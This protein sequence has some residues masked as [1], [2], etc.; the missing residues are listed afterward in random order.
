MKSILIFILFI[1][2]S[3]GCNQA[4]EISN[5]DR[6]LLIS[7]E[8]NVSGI[9]ELN[10]ELYENSQVKDSAFNSMISS[11]LYKLHQL[12][13]Y[14]VEASGGYQG[15]FP[16]RTE[17]VNNLS[18]ESSLILKQNPYGITVDYLN[19][20]PNY[21]KTKGLKVG[22]IAVNPKDDPFGK[23]S[24]DN[25]DWFDLAFPEKNVYHVLIV[26]ENLKSQILMLERRYLQSRLN[27]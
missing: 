19:Q 23:D 11:T 18:G 17:I 4:N 3:F 7:S 27:Y 9:R 6:Y 24:A 26:I 22:L 1:I 21:L 25:R 8:I 2:T 16:D 12:Q 10:K 20:I 14:A 5:F 15:R 13:E